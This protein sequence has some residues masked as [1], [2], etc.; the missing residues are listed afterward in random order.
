MA[1]PLKGLD[2]LD[3]FFGFDRHAQRVVL[4]KRWWAP[5]LMSA[6]SSTALLVFVVLSS[7]L[8]TGWPIVVVAV[9]IMMVFC[10][11]NSGFLYAHN[12]READRKS[13]L[14]WLRVF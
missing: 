1:K 10:S 4:M 3:A 14:P 6:L 13:R 8:Q 11:F 9:G 5:L 2:G 12:L 7:G